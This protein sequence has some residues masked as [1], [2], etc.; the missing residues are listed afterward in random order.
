MNS[1]R[2]FA[3]QK[4]TG[5]IDLYV[6]LSTACA[7]EK[8]LSRQN[9]KAD[10]RIIGFSLSPEMATNVKKEA[11][12]RGISLRKLFEELWSNYNVQKS[13]E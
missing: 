3:V 6:D 7:M 8:Q 4:S 2:L 1:S 5:M 11:T 13:S 9:K 10:R 12:L